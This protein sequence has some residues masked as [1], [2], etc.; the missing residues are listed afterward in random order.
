MSLRR[1]RRRSSIQSLHTSP[2]STRAPPMRTATREVRAA[3]IASEWA[4][5]R[6]LTSLRCRPHS[7]RQASPALCSSPSACHPSSV[8]HPRQPARGRGRSH[9]LISPP[10]RVSNNHKCGASRRP[11]RGA[12]VDAITGR[13]DPA[14]VAATEIDRSPVPD[15]ECS[16]CPPAQDAHPNA[17]KAATATPSP[18]STTH[19]SV[20]DFSNNGSSNTPHTHR[21]TPNAATTT[22]SHL[23]VRL[24]APIPTLQHGRSAPAI[25]GKT[26]IRRRILHV[27]PI[28]GWRTECAYPDGFTRIDTF[29]YAAP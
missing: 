8:Q 21:L 9:I 3:M 14:N 13:G 12:A 25:A 10:S 18:A 27:E 6:D 4:Q 2:T 17:A 28:R 23:V 5:Y 11:D 20:P 1:S 19:R 26:R 7:C 29:A 15:E 16:D 22:T 24:I